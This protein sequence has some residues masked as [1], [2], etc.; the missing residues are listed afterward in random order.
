MRVLQEREFERVG[1]NKTI[2]VDVR[3][4]TATNKDLD[5]E[6]AEGRFREDLYYRLNVVDINLPPLNE[7]M[8][9]LLLLV[10][11]FIE[12]FNHE[13]GKNIK[14]LSREAIKIISTYSWPGNIRELE[15]VIEHAFVKCNKPTIQKQHLPQSVVAAKT[16]SMIK[17]GIKKGLSRDQIEK[18]ILLNTLGK[19]NWS[20]GLVT[21]KLNISRSTL[22]RKMKKYNMSTKRF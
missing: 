3:I 22:W 5:N 20:L 1:G 11:H 13:T 21:Q 12:K 18:D 14:G 17:N 10:T 4:I 8:D 9:D 15:H 6:V 2:K 7:R 16:D 19:C